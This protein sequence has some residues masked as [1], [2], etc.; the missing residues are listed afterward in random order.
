MTDRAIPDHPKPT[1]SLEA[2]ITDLFFAVL[3]LMRHHLVGAVAEMGLTPQQ[4]HALRCLVPGHP[5]PMRDLATELMCDAS[6]VTGIVDRLEER[7]L[8]RRQPD[9]SDRRVKAL[10][11]TDAGEAARS[12]L[13][14]RILREAPHVAGLSAPERA[15]LR[16]L[17]RRIVASA[18]GEGCHAARP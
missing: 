4:A 13:W 2:E 14:E 3:G 9:V 10:V 6:T 15:Q 17:L 16:D 1:E 5:L 18:P 7:G 8:V 12:R 11:V